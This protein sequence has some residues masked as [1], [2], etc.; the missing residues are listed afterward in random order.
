ML[1]VYMVLGA[2][3]FTILVLGYERLVGSR[4]SGRAWVGKRSYPDLWL[5][6]LLDCEY[7]PTRQSYGPARIL[8]VT[9]LKLRPTTKS[10]ETC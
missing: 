6:S 1:L 7:A 10:C 8:P 9:E 5:A 3:G 4:N 2:L